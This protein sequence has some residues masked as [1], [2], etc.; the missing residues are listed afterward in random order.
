MRLPQVTFALLLLWPAANL[1]AADPVD[2][3]RA[4]SAG[5]RKIGSKHLILYTD[6][7]ASDDVD[8]LP[9]VFDQAVPQWAEYFQIDESK[10]ANWQAQACLIGERRRFDCAGLDAGRQ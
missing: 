6:L 5:I 3:S 4:Q 10:T 7:P 8:Q 2:E 9:A 1:A